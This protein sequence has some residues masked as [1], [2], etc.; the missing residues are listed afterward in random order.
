MIGFFGL[1]VVLVYVAFKLNYRAGRQYETV[2]LN[3]D[4]L[5]VRRVHP[6][7][8]ARE[9]R[10][11]PF[12]LRVTVEQPQTDDSR[13]ILSSHGKHLAL[14]GFLTVAERLDLATALNAAL[15]KWRAGP[16]A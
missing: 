4:E 16:S 14:G 5:V 7:G 2:E 8:A 10:F 11:E 1:D 15:V 9:W 13:L 12:W 3:A 6:G